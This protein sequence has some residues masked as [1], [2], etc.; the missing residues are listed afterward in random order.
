[1]ITNKEY[2]QLKSFGVGLCKFKTKFSNVHI[3][4]SGNKII[5]FTTDFVKLRIRKEPLINEIGLF[6]FSNVNMHIDAIHGADYKTL[7]I[8]VKG[9]GELAHFVNDEIEHSLFDL[10]D[11]RKVIILDDHKPHS[12]VSDTANCFAILASIHI[13]SI[14]ENL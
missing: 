13:D 8:P 2:K 14:P 10:E 6:G 5:D 11:F 4:G 3:I 1:M 9:R 12:F 7:I